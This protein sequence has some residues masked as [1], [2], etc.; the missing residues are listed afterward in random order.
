MRAARPSPACAGPSL[1]PPARHRNSPVGQTAVLVERS[2]ASAMGFACGTDGDRATSTHTAA[3]GLHRL[4]LC[5][6]CF[7]GRSPET[8][9]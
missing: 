9:C 7:V 2:V 4:F 6:F 8:R 3:T 1:S 5:F